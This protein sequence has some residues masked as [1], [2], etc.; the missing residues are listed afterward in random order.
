MVGVTRCCSELLKEKS[1]GGQLTQTGMNTQTLRIRSLFGHLKHLNPTNLF[2]VWTPKLLMK[3]IVSNIFGGG[4][5]ASWLDG[6]TAIIILL[7]CPA[8]W[9]PTVDAP[10][11]DSV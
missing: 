6:F 5:V 8:A 10:T 11:I 1:T 3:G 4:T 7:C 2:L 9:I